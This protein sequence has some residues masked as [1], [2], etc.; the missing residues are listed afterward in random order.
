MKWIVIEGYMVVTIGCTLFG[1][2]AIVLTSGR[3]SVHVRTILGDT[4]VMY[5]YP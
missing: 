2:S 1:H 3:L 5:N 4:P